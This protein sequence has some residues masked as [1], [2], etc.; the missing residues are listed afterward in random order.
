MGG[1]KAAPLLTSLAR[2]LRNLAGTRAQSS[3]QASIDK[4]EEKIV[5]A[6]RRRAADQDVVEACKSIL[7]TKTTSA[8]TT[9]AKEAAA[10]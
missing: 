2:G 4:A 3:A 7:A 10:S 5:A 9:T 1:R 6:M 8:K